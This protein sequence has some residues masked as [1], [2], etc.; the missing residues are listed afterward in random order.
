MKTSTLARHLA[1]LVAAFAVVLFACNQGSQGD[2]CNPNLSHDEC[3]SGL[4]CV[5]PPLCPEAY[6]C[7][8]DANGNL[9]PNSDPNCQIGCNG[10]AASACNAG[11]DDAGQCAFACAHDPGDLASASVC[12]GEDA[13][14][15]ASDGGTG[16]SEAGSD[17]GHD[18]GGSS[19]GGDAG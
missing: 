7:P 15:D 9:L 3:N 18:A 11:A 12:A 2:R 5:S 4:S 8:T 10:G 16:A 19:D 1:S 6:C 17:S 14:P 13:G